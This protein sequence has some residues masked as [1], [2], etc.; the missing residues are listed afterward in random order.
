MKLE[1]QFFHFFFYPFLLGVAL[2]AIIII[3]CPVIFTNDYIDKITGNN[4]IELGKEYSEIK[5]YSIKEL[6]ST[7]LLKM[8]LSLSELL[9]L[10]QKL[11]NKLK[12][13][14]TN[15]DRKIN[16][17]F[18]VSVLDL[19]ETLNETFNQSYNM[20]YW[21]LDLETNLEKLKPGSIEENQLIAFSKMMQNV[22][23]V[24]YSANYTGTNFYFYFE[25]NEL[26]ISFPLIYDIKNEFIKEIT[27][28]TTNPVWCTDEKGDVYTYYKMK[29]RGFYDNIKKAKSDV[30]DIN[31]K[32]NENRTFF[33]T[34]FY[35]QVAL[36][37]EI[38][39]TICIEFTDPLSNKLAYLCADINSNDL[40]YNFDNIN[41]KLSGYFFVNSVGFSHSFYYPGGQ[42]ESLTIT[43]NIFPFDKAFF[44]EEKTYF[45][46]NIQRL[47]SSNYI[48]YINDA[49]NSLNQEVFIN[50]VN[51]SDQS[52]YINGEKF[53][54]SIYPVVL[55]NFKGNRE[56]VLNIIYLYNNNLFYDEIKMK[57]NLGVKIVLELI[58]IILFGS[59]L[60]YIIVLS[61]N[62]LAKYI[63][64]PIKNVNYMLKGIN[65][66]G[67]NRL[68]YLDFLKKRQDDNIEMLE[69]MNFDE[70]EKDKNDANN[71]ETSSNNLKEDN[72]EKSE[73]KEE[74]NLIDNNNEKENTKSFD[75]SD[76]DDDK[77]IKDSNITSNY[78]KFEEENEFI[79][80]ESTFYNFDEQLL[81][82]RPLEI[83]RLLKE[84]INLKGALL[85]TSTDQ[86]VEQIINYSNSENIFRNFKN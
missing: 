17:E 57:N 40:N 72:N 65:I 53:L 4:L 66:G 79:E 21:I 83:D 54:Y 44:L 22:Y 18:L 8:Q 30:F 27:N 51:N 38:V 37:L 3:V 85:L 75:D 41:T 49:N 50:G 16:E 80:K 19:N 77:E 78:K 69:K 45:Y 13:N 26:Y 82:Y 60:L 86:Q 47:L 48:K 29:C 62:T 23:S 9:L 20:A 7:N 1:D 31:Y 42:E 70:N 14:N 52:F 56:H 11:A 34:E 64:I 58:V 73:L 81:Q 67:K 6:L 15:L 24:F 46:N 36:G 71:K 59:G 32:D 74:T 2:S 5:I 10:Y 35:T 84:L 33:V 12:A 39:F 55:E 43:E 63:V 61:F 28:Y 25:S 68:E 76:N